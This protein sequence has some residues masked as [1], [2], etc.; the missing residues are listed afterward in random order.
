MGI[1]R[2]TNFQIYREIIAAFTKNGLGFL[3]IKNTV[4]TIRGHRERILEDVRQ[5]QGVSIGERIRK[6][7]EELGPT[8]I[9]IGQ[10]LSTRTDIITPN[11]ANELAKLQ[12]SVPPFPFACAREVIEGEFGDK[13]ENIFL[14]FAQTPIASA[15]MS[16]VYLAKLQSGMDVAVKV[17][18]P[19]IRQI[20]DIDISILK[21][22]AKFVDKYTKYGDM[23]DFYGMVE[24][25]AGV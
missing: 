25:F 11:V 23:Y 13:L 1:E 20:V 8:F 4:F 22:I 5:K 6:T 24:E 21:R 12:D 16:Q 7:C 15:S 3:F 10:F 2:V 17:Q 14:Y 18:R 9:K 19:D